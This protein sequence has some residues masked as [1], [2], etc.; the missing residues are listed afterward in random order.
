MKTDCLFCQIID[1]MVPAKIVYQDEKVIAFLDINPNNPG[2]TL[3]IPRRHHQDFFTLSKNELADLFAGVQTVAGVIKKALAAE[4]INLGMNNGPA[5]GQVIFH[6]H[7]HII[8]RFK[9]DGL[10]HWQP[11]KISEK[12]MTVIQDKIRRAV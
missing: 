11:K 3:V 2:H 6:A 10:I 4:G 8:P 12:E 7:I 1:G 5:A 9:D